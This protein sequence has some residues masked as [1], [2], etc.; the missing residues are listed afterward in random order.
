MKCVYTALILFLLLVA[1][2][3]ET[4]QL[5][6]SKLPEKADDLKSLL[7]EDP[8]DHTKLE[9][10]YALYKIYRKEDPQLALS[11][12]KKQHELAESLEDYTTLGK[13]SYN[14]GLIKKKEGNYLEALH[15]YLLSISSFEKVGDNS[16]IPIVLD[17]IGNVFT[18]V[19]NYDYA[20]KFY[21][22]S[23]EFY[24]ENEDTKNLAIANLNLGITN[25]STVV[26]NYTEA[27]RCFIEAIKYANN[28][29]DR[30]DYFLN[31][32]YNQLGTMNY[33]KGDYE[34]AV[35]YY[36]LSLN[37]I[38]QDGKE[39]QQAV[40]YANIGEV[41]MDQ[42]LFGKAEQHIDKSLEQIS[43]ITAN[44]R[45]IGIFNIK[46]RLFQRQG[47]FKQGVEY[48]EKAINIA[49]KEI[50]NKPLQESLSHIRT[51]YSELRKTN[52]AVSV[53]RYENILFI[54][55]KQD[56]L[57]EALVEKTNFKSLQAALA[58]K[59]ELEYEKRAKQSAM[60]LKFLYGNAAFVLGAIALAVGVLMF[61]FGRKIYLIRKVIG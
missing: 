26:P 31:R 44:Q 7:A 43:N 1:C 60:E 27:E 61:V 39:E 46:G 5:T 19:G 52:R 49:N 57:E 36:K 10:Y 16:R 28:L 11:Y 59:V 58:L 3:N 25:F 18:E 13:S 34:E 12:L 40:A 56:K 42:G 53:E 4:K 21:L 15:H 35:K 6:P 37:H 14:M 29:K 55:D 54:D 22:K 38:E 48:F 47:K 41:Y 23:I 24:T 51:G 8:N 2:N 45:I 17:N 30:K 9:I 32:I 33:R 20:K 50:I